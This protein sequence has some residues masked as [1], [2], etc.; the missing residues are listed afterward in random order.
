MVSYAAGAAGI[1]VVLCL[2]GC[3]SSGPSPQPSRS[4]SPVRSATATVVLSAPGSMVSPGCSN[5]TTAEVSNQTHSVKAG[6]HARLYLMTT[7]PPH[8]LPAPVVVDFHGYGEGDTTESLTTQLGPLGQRD[9]FIS[10]FPE[11]RGSPIA[12]D[13][14]TRPGNPDVTFVAAMLSRLEASQCVDEARIYATGLSQGAFMTSTMACVM[15]SRFAAF[16]AVSGVQLPTP[17]PASRPVPIL[18][19]HGTADPILHFNGGLGRAVLADD[20][21]AHAKRLP[22]LAKAR[23]NGSGYPATVKAWAA[24]DGCGIRPTN[25]RL[26]PHVIHRIYPCPAGVAV[27]FDIILGGG[28]SWPGSAFSAEIAKFVGHTTTEINASQAIWSFLRRFH[29]LK[30]P[31][32]GH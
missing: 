31:G 1:A 24:K 22:K 19:F 17:C 14:S 7:P 29:L 10:V 2:A 27:E 6:G 21:S 25:T 4:T 30:L 23:L 13:T 20:L 32:Q 5:A 18:A 16:A 26:S 28:H 8:R 3:S 11:G 9:G 15:S 12:W